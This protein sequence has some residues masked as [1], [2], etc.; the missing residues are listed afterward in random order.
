MQRYSHPAVNEV[1]QLVMEHYYTDGVED[2]SEQG[3][4]IPTFVINFGT[5]Y[6]M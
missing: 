5:C 3:E 2:S 1:T 6:W 4:I